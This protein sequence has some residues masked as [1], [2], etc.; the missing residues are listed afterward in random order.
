MS[1]VESAKPA[2]V[3][4]NAVPT[5]IAAIRSPATAGPMMR[6]PLQIEELN[7]TALGIAA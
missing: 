2:A 4:K 6:V 7:A 1:S 5:P 3:T